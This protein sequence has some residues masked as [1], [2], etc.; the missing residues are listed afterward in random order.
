MKGDFV[1]EYRMGG[2]QS[3][4]A[5]CEFWVGPRQP[6]YFGSAVILPEQSIYGQCFCLESSMARAQ[7]LSN[8]CACR[9]YKKWSLIK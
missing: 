3:L 6:D 2:N 4:C 9:H 1:V 7:R 5:T 8:T